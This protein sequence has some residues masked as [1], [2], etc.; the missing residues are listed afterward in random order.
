MDRDGVGDICDPCAYIASN[1]DPDDADGDGVGDECDNC[2]DTYN[3][4]QFNSDRMPFSWRAI[5]ATASSERSATDG[6]AL[7]AI[8]PEYTHCQSA[9]TNWAPLDGGS[10]PEWLDLTFPAAVR[11]NEVVVFQSGVEQDFL[12]RIEL[13]DLHGGLHTVWDRQIEPNPAPFCGADAGFQFPTTPFEVDGVVVHTQT[14]GLEEID[15]VLL[16]GFGPRSPDALGNACDGCPA[17]SRYGHPADGD[18]DGDGLADAC[19]CSPDDGTARDPADVAGVTVEAPSR[20]T[21]RMNWPAAPGADTYAVT[22]GLLSGLGP[23]QYGS[24]LTTDL[25]T[26]WFE[27]TEQPPAGDGYFYF[28]QGVDGVCGIGTLGYAI[29]GEERLNRDPQAC[30]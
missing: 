6:S 28:V 22:R 7:Q 21:L 12:T 14:P 16:G 1:F 3:P 24:C 26:E 9:A 27:D 20:G 13:R 10:D 15:A 17:D 4:D 18:A 23:G 29:D 19:D 30:Q 8:V 2:P 11:A 25:T 5:D